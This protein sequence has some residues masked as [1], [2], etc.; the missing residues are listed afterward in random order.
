VGG[1]LVELSGI[2]AGYAGARVL[3]GVSFTVGEGETWA[4]LGPN[5]AGKSSLA[6]VALGLLAPSK[7]TV[8][9]A[10]LDVAATAASV[11][12]RRAAW[13][14][15][16]I[17]EDVA[18][19]GLEVALMGRAPH[20]GAFGLAGGKDVERATAALAALG[21]AHL[22]NR[23]MNQVSGGERRRV[24]L[25]RALVQ[26]PELLVLDEPTAFLD[27]RHQVETLRLV[28]GLVLSPPP[29]AHRLSAA[30]AVL[31]DPSLAAH[32]ATHALL[33]RDGAVQAQ[34]RVEEVLTAEQL[35]TLYG[36]A[37]RPAEEADR[38]FFPRWEAP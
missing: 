27:V 37:M 14:P 28:R 3:Q 18:F 31:H 16:S 24:W 29:G 11:L 20:L 33:L 10:G 35:T 36:I 15:Q 23:P 32:F 7:G 19:T 1:P 12:A 6:K 8:R 25:A 26:E 9:V 5:G 30:V 22:S 21:V 17:R 4:I 34:G 38:V 2:E 13:V